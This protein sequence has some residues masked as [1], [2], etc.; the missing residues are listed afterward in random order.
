MLPTQ[1]CQLTNTSQGG[2]GKDTCPE[3]SILEPVT[4]WPAL[5]AAPVG[6]SGPCGFNHRVN[7][8]YNT[9]GDIYGTK[10]VATYAPGDVI[11]VEWCVD[12]NGDHGGMFA[13]RICQ[14]QALV[15]KF[16]TPGYIPTDAEKQEAEDCFTKGTLPCTEVNGQACGFSADCTQG[17]ECWRNDWFT[18][19]GFNDSKC[20]GIDA[21]PLNSCYTSIAGGYTVTKKVKIPDYVSEHTLLSF[22]WNSFQTPQIYLSCADIAIVGSASSPNPPTSPASST[23]ATTSAKPVTTLSTKVS[24][25]AAPSATGACSVTFEEKVKTNVGQ[26]IKIAGSVAALGSWDTGAA[27]K[28]SASSY[29]D[30]NPLWSTTLSLAA[31]LSIEYKFIKVESSG[32]VTYESGK[33]RVYTVP[34]ECKG[35]VKVATEW[36]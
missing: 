25:T 28:L 23:V 3:C 6:M 21:A 33:N 32:S 19:N 29:T 7:V 34:Q 20:R 36:Q 30:A 14:D 35:G 31:G 2:K 17:Q 27:P 22:K 5:D 12:A 16:T 8:D 4:A 24:T 18:C 15:D 13:Y 26:T 9:P 11:D 10:T 1:G